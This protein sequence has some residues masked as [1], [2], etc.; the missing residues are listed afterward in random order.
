MFL[1]FLIFAE[2][3]LCIRSWAACSSV[4]VLVMNFIIQE[5][6]QGRFMIDLVISVFRLE[7]S[8]VDLVKII[9]NHDQKTN[10]D[11]IKYPEF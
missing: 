7:M 2:S 6:D 9:S 10:T 5:C 8:Q 11:H 3:K 1:R 4:F